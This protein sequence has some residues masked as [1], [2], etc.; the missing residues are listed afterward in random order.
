MP[1]T[2]H[3][4]LERLRGGADAA[5]WQRM[6]DLYTPVLRVWL[7]RHLLQDADCEDLIQEMLLQV[8]REVPRFE[9][10]GRTGAFRCWLR[11]LLVNRVRALRRLWPVTPTATGDSA[12]R[13][14]LDRL[15]DPASDL[16]RRWDEEHDRAVVRRLLDMIRADFEPATWEAFRRLTVD[17]RPAAA[18]AA[19]LGVSRNAVY[20]AKARVMARLQQELGGLVD[21]A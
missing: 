13:E 14:R 17:G 11:L 20:L 4:L 19:E 15:E 3:T 6:T 21:L 2:S 5:S 12:F 10:N 7:R 1:E 18:V 16:S 8:L 9:H